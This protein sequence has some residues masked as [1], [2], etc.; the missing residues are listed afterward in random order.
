MPALLPVILAGGSGTRL[1]PLSR[2]EKP[3]QFLSLISDKSLLQETVQRTMPFT[4]VLPPLVI[5][6]HQHRFLV[7]EQLQ[8]MGVKP[9]AIIIEPIGRNTAPAITVAALFA[10]EKF[11]EALL[12]V[13]P[14]DHVINHLENFHQAIEVARRQASHDKLITLGIVPTHAETGFGYIQRGEAEAD[15]SIYQVSR[16]VEKPD[17]ETAKQYVTQGDYYWNSGMFVFSASRFLTEI[18][19]YEPTVFSACLQAFQQRQED[20][21][22][23][24]LEPQAFGSSPSISIDYAVME[25]TT[26]A[27]VV[28][29]D[30][31]WSDV[32]SWQALFDMSAKDREGNVL[33]GNVVVDQVND[34]Y[35]RAEHRLLAVVGVSDLIVIET[36]AAILVADRAHAQNIKRFVESPK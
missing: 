21:D 19:A 10:Q 12:C 9:S 32:G 17:I 33:R 34:C 24:R 28:P 5:C 26:D 31:G 36:E 4:E 3:K 6:N 16:F 22:F 35:L 14:S 15:N 18:K 20:A 25:K 27:M 1:W 7:A 8:E 29:M 13:M 11:K 30:A 2:V 23:L